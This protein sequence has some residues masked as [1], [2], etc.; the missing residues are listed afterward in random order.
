MFFS[1]FAKILYKHSAY[2]NYSGLFVIELFNHLLDDEELNPFI[3][4]G[5]STLEKYF[6]GNRNLPKKKTQL[7]YSH[8]D[9]YKF[10][11]YIDHLSP[12]NQLALERDFQTIDP[13]FN[14]DDALGYACAD[15]LIELLDDILEDQVH[16]Y[17]PESTVSQPLPPKLNPSLLTSSAVYY[18]SNDK[19]L[20]IN[21]NTIDIPEE[22]IPSG[23]AN[24][25]INTPYI[26]ALLSAFGSALSQ[27]KISVEDLPAHYRK[28][29]QRQRINYYSARR[30]D[31][32]VRESVA[33]G[34]YEMGKWKQE[35][36]DYIEETLEDSYPDGEQRLNKVMQKVV[37]CSTTS[38][39][40]HFQNFIGP[41]ERK[42]ACHLLVNDRKFTW[43]NADDSTF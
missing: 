23:L 32:F 16:S 9:I 4:S 11:D 14:S 39:L 33:N 25:E 13:N 21:E 29:F 15:L 35:T 7:I 36:F 8:K 17:K 28:K 1:E 2:T 18:D 27:D 20:H 40:D 22:L 42:G 43:M 37:D 12:A 10:A 19:K 31:R 24:D 38:V 30:I 6:R 41:K 34:E 5:E 3:E 26:Q